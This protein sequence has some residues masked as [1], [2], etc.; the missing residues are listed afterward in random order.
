MLLFSQPSEKTYTPLKWKAA[1]FVFSV[2]K[3]SHVAIIWQFEW[4][5]Q[6]PL[7][8]W[9]SGRMAAPSGASLSSDPNSGGHTTFTADMFFFCFVFFLSKDWPA[10]SLAKCH[11]CFS[12]PSHPTFPRCCVCQSLA[13]GC[14]EGRVLW[15]LFLKHYFN[16]LKMS[17]F[18]PLPEF[19]STNNCWMITRGKGLCCEYN[20]GE[21]ISW[22]EAWSLMDT[23]TCQ[24]T[25]V[26]GVCAGWSQA[27]FIGHLAAF[28]FI[29]S[30]LIEV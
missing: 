9:S 15:N 8:L 17:F 26:G 12:H 13:R 4:R 14:F 7:A 10:G 3:F 29:F 1:S 18:P 21:N 2:H 24:L 20:K 19:T 28:N 5:G 25:L 6:R 16:V 23:D 22:Q 27:L 30:I 11:V